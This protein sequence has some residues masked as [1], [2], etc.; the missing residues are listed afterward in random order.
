MNTRVLN[1][2]DKFKLKCLRNILEIPTTY[3]NR[4]FS[5]AV[6]R[7]KVNEQLKEAKATPVVTL[8]EFHTKKTRHSY[9]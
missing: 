5:N 2:L 9:L 3:I 6:V 8:A 7:Q 1:L 4:E